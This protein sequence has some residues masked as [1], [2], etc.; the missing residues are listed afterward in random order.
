M[1]ARPRI[2]K[3]PLPPPAKKRKR[4][5]AVE[6]I[7]FDKDA[8]TEYL[9][10][11]HKRKQQRIKVAQEAAAEKARQEKIEFRKQVRWFLL[12]S[13]LRTREESPEESSWRSVYG[14][15]AC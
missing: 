3:N 12:P 10:G 11:F 9:T 5:H 1:F 2:R 6:E 7:A 13:L 8:R 15:T 14:S 4:D